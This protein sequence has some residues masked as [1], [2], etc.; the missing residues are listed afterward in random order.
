M[1]Y[2]LRHKLSLWLVRRAA[3][4]YPE[5]KFRAEA[6]NFKVGKRYVR[7]EMKRFQEL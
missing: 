5:I 6:Y 2:N 7:F 3:N 1:L 4:V